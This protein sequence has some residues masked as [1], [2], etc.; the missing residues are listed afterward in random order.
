MNINATIDDTPIYIENIRLITLDL[1]DKHDEYL[2]VLDQTYE[3][4][5]NNREWYCNTYS[6]INNIDIVTDPIF[7]T[8]VDV[9]TALVKDYARFYGIENATVTCKDA[10]INLAKLKDYQEFHLH[11]NSH[12]SVVYYVKVPPNSGNLILR[13]HVV[14]NDMFSLPTSNHNLNPLCYRTYSLTP[15]EGMMVI[16]RSNIE[17]MVQANMSNEDRVSIAMNM[18]I[19]G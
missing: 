14:T 12:F 11:T 15:K 19:D 18:V 7:R 10:W 1:K 13:N 17:H 4:Y 9:S 5:P 3:K 8:L 6:T 16:F 2:K